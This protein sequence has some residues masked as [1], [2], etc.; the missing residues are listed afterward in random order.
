MVD[1]FYSRPDSETEP[2]AV[3]EALIAEFNLGDRGASTL[4]VPDVTH[5]ALSYRAFKKVRRS[6]TKKGVC[7]MVRRA[8]G[9]PGDSLEDRFKMDFRRAAVA[10]AKQRGA[11]AGNKGRPREV[12]IAKVRKLADGGMK[13]KEIIKETGY[14]ASNVYRALKAA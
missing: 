13:P 14:A 1:R 11:Y 8:T 10:R 4:T 2:G 12:D 7:L 6:L 9:R 3:L 5:L